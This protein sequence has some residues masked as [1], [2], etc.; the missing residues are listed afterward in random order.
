MVA[1]RQRVGATQT[2]IKASTRSSLRPLPNG[3]A[4]LTLLDTPTRPVKAP[5]AELT[6][7]PHHSSQLFKNYQPR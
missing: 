5:A 6:L 2:K 7:F 4:V 1:R 3:D